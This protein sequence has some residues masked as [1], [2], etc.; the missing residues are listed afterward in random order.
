MAAARAGFAWA[1]LRYSARRLLER[2]GLHLGEDVEWIKADGFGQTEVFD[3][4]DPAVPAF[5]A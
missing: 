5:Y 3:H 4:I 2:D 1:V